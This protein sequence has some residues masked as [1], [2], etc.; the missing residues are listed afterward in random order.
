MRRALPAFVV[1]C[2]AI[3]LSLAEPTPSPS[4][5]PTPTPVAL[6][7]ILARENLW[8]TKALDYDLLTTKPSNFVEQHQEAGFR[9]ISSGRDTAESYRP[10][11]TL[12][13]LPVCQTVCRFAQGKL[14]AVIVSFYNRGD[15]GEL[16][17]NKFEPLVKQSV[18][19]VSD[20]TKVKFTERGR[21]ATSAVK[22][23]GFVWQTGKSQ[24][25]IEYSFTKLPPSGYRAEF[26]RLTVTPVEKPK[27]LLD[28]SLAA[29]QPATKFFGT[30]HLKKDANGDVFIGDIPM[31][32]Q[33]PKG[34]CV[35]ASAE[36]VMR[37]YGVR[38]DQNELAQIAN[39]SAEKGTS[40][41]AML[42]SL[43]NLSNRLRIKTR[44][45]ETFDKTRFDMLIHDYNR[46]AKLDH[47]SEISPSIQTMS[48][49]IRAMNPDV[50]RD[51][52]TKNPSDMNRFNRLAQAHINQGI[53]LLWSVMIGVLRQ[54]KD[55]SLGYGGHMRLII[56]YNAKTNEI[57]YS[58]SWG[59][60]HEMERMPLADAWSIT[61]GLSAIEPL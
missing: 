11:L 56:G 1:C 45:I 34:Y 55:P 57:I 35:V 24:F 5:S 19:A 3:R 33:G 50:L 60:G 15:A 46:Y 52:R 10:N 42:D 40:P 54:P 18:D 23:T 20:F 37:Y 53:P 8:E 17:R 2:T 13:N 49:L 26:L 27:S 21:D 43:K 28:Q 25:L 48:E 58:D 9:W 61:T 16:P 47:E 36:R 14:S 30:T 29:S 4:P 44:T 39:S 12:F 51:A 6:D 22:A 7:S 32:D 31:V 59:F 38:I 41:A